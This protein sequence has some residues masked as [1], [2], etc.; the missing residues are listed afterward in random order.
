MRRRLA[1]R[2][3]AMSRRKAIRRRP[4]MP[5]CQEERDA[6]RNRQMVG[7]S[8]APSMLRAPQRSNS[9]ITDLPFSH[10]GC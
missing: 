9:L 5:V 1:T 7:Q 8:M 2:R 6:A 10:R 3:K 4:V